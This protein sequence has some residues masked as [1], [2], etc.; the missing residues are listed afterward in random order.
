[1]PSP[2]SNNKRIAKNTL[3]LYFRQILIM[4]VSL[5]TVRI[6][7]KV[8]GAEDYGIYTVVAG[9]VTMFGFLSGAMATASQRYFSFDLGKKDNEHLKTTFSVTLQIYI[10]IALII[11]F[12]AETLGLW[13]VLNK[14]VIPEERLTAAVWIY[15]AAII[16]FLLT[17][18]TTPYM[19]SLIAHE[20]MNIYAYVS[21]IE[22]IL[23]LVIVFLIQIL[24]YD[25]LIVYAFFLTTVSF[26]I[27]FIYRTYCQ[28]KYQECK[29]QL[30]KDKQLFKEIISYSGWNLFGNVATICK[31]QGVAIIMN[32]F[33]GPIINAA[34][35]IAN[36][37]SSV[38]STF[39]NN[40]LQAVRPQII[41]SYAGNNYEDMW[42]TTFLGCKISYFLVLLIVTALFSNIDHIFTL[43]LGDVPQYTSVFSQLTLIA[44]LIQSISLPMATVNQATGKI[45]IYQTIIG[46]IVFLN[47]PISYLFLH[48]GFAP[49]IIYAI[50]I[51]SMI[52]L[53]IIRLSFLYR[54]PQFNLKKII[55]N[56]ILPCGIVSIIM[57]LYN[58]LINL[59][60]NTLLTLALDVSVKILLCSIAIF[61]FGFSKKEKNSIIHLI[62][63]KLR[64]SND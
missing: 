2:V 17:L 32:I 37:I 40:F 24:P 61:L 10:L 30:I 62:T 22:A 58:Q 8:L 25:K 55:L 9:V 34:Q 33:F 50:S 27:T 49:T 7:L 63:S 59:D 23:K 15:H 41:K 12:L 53:V 45:A 3:L 5:Y 29:F 1:M 18:I 57:S 47:L 54:I 51:I 20:N 21:I 36:Q 38:T 48:L 43:W 13:F 46:I 44:I 11:I 39:S 60:K 19:A 64:I 28:K 35:G 31:N 56:V 14:L 26:I 6:V 16:S 4:L 42:K 52:G